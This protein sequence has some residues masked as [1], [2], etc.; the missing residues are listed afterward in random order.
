MFTM[1]SNTIKQLSRNRLIFFRSSL[2]D[3][4]GTDK[5]E[6]CDSNRNITTI[7]IVLHYFI[8]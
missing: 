8:I 5:L 3:K 4:D 1:Q 6:N 7:T 2:K